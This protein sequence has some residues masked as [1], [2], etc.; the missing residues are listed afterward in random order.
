MNYREVS[1]SEIKRSKYNP[2]I[3]TDKTKFAYKNL[4]QSIKNNGLIVPII[5]NNSMKLIDGHRRLSCCEDLGYDEIPAIINS[6]VTNKNYDKMFTE[7]NDKT[8]KM[9][10]SQETE[11]YLSGASNISNAVLKQIKILEEIG[12]RDVI[13]KIV[14]MGQSPATYTIGV[15]MYCAYTNKRTKKDK[16]EVLYWMFNV[17]SPYALKTA[18]NFFIPA[19]MLVEFIKERKKITANWT[20]KGIL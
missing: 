6:S 12:G 17:S 4:L 7:A 3:R 20:K 2:R 16:R 15:G 11:R 9:T 10:A 19:D 5:L 14:S 18:I 8:M 1:I 13:K